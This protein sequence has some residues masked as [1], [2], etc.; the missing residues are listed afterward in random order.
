MDATQCLNLPNLKMENNAPINTYTCGPSDSF[1]W[2]FVGSNIHFAKDPSFC[3]N[4]PMNAAT[5][6]TAVQLY[7]CS[8][9]ISQQWSYTGSKIHSKKNEN[10]CLG[11]T[12]PAQATNVILQPCTQTSTF[13]TLTPGVI[14]NSK[15]KCG[16]N[17]GNPLGC[18]VNG[19]HCSSTTKT[20]TCEG[21]T[22][23]CCTNAPGNPVCCQDGYRC[24][25]PAVG[26]NKC[27]QTTCEIGKGHFMNTNGACIGPTGDYCTNALY[28]ETS[29][30]P[31]RCN[32]ATPVCCTTNV[33]EPICCKS[34]QTCG[35]SWTG[36]NECKS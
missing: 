28:P 16:I 1:N 23:V 13:W 18:C 6:G 10:V 35:K 36:G 33:R 29:K 9:H 14:V 34:G 2:L 30:N 21:A 20:I 5:S 25:S 3:L 24:S 19:N 4:I 15:C 7:K 32:G 31:I 12:G 11:V 8:S 26:D 17:S 27:V 22:P